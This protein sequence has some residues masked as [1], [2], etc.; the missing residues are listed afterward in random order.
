MDLQEKIISPVTNQD[1]CKLLGKL[2]TKI[3]LSQYLN[4]IQLDVKRFFHDSDLNLYECPA[5]GYRFYYPPSSMG[6]GK[7]YEDLEAYCKGSYYPQNK[8]EYSEALKFVKAGDRV[9][10]IGCGNGAFYRLCNKKGI[11]HF[12]GLE[13]NEKVVKEL[14][15]QGLDVSDIPVEAFA[16]KNIRF[17]VVC[18]FQVLEDR[19][20]V[21]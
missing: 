16:E 20:S 17:N 19:K 7:F 18:S 11:K 9:L 15:G 3:I 5:T 1:E 13:L 12:T 21:V 10:E 8:W 2:D 4:D 6:D 14:R